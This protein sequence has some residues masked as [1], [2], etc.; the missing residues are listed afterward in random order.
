MIK[1]F[2]DLYFYL[3]LSNIVIIYCGSKKIRTLKA[4]SGKEWCVS[5]ETLN[6]NNTK[7]APV[8]VVRV[9]LTDDDN[10]TYKLHMFYGDS[11]NVEEICRNY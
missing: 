6:D 2:K 7:S 9:R 11:I 5:H 3:F 8:K 10:D 4:P 1:F